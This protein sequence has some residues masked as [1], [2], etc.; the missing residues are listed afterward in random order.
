MSNPT[1]DA[2][3]LFERGHAALQ[4]GDFHEAVE[5]LSRAVALR[6]TVA[7]GY[8]FRAYAFLALKDRARAVADFGRAG[9]RS[10]RWRTRSG[11]A[12]STGSSPGA[13]SGSRAGSS[14]LLP[15]ERQSARPK[16][17]YRP[18]T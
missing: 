15:R 3:A 5:C 17:C 10:C 6:P 1:S 7:A 12:T 11:R 9:R 16:R 18:L 8:R 14:A 13:G 2:E 4:A